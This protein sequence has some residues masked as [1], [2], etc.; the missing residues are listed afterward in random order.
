M[1]KLL[2]LI[3]AVV[4]FT[5]GIIGYAMVKFSKNMENWEMAWDDEEDKEVV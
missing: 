4:G 5:A 2:L 1:K 3:M